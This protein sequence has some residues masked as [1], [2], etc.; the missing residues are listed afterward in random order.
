ML[1]MVLLDVKNKNSYY[2]LGFGLMFILSIIIAIKVCYRAPKSFIENYLY[3]DRKIIKPSSIVKSV[4]IFSVM[5][6][7]VYKPYRLVLILSYLLFLFLVGA[8]TYSI[9]EYKQYDKIQ[10]LKKQ[11][12]YIPPKK[13]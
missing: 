13:K 10:E 1:E 2:A 12:H 5:I 7:N 8:M 11:I 9:F 4:A 3:K 6:A